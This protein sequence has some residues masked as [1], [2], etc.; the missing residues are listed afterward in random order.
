MVINPRL[1]SH[2]E[3]TLSRHTRSLDH[4]RVLRRDSSMGLDLGIRKIPDIDLDFD[5]LDPKGP[6]SYQPTVLQDHYLG[7]K[8][9]RSALRFDDSSIKYELFREKSERREYRGKRQGIAL[10]YAT[11]S[12]YETTLD[13]KRLRVALK[14]RLSDVRSEDVCINNLTERGFAQLASDISSKNSVY[15]IGVSPQYDGEIAADQAWAL[16]VKMENPEKDKLKLQRRVTGGYKYAQLDTTKYKLTS[17]TIDGK[18]VDNVY[19]I[20]WRGNP[21]DV[22]AIGKIA[23]SYFGL[24]KPHQTRIYDQL[25]PKPLN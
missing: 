16:I 1:R 24:V 11:T 22:Q 10:K 5:S 3:R 14:K 13:G 19:I 23:E 12:P 21:N 7:T 17:A 25:K 2:I 15:S 9:E 18:R 4:R 6:T 20:V 8:R